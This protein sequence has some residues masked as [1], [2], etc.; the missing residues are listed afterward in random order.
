[1]NEGRHFGVKRGHDLVGG[2]D[3]ADGQAAVPQILGHLDADETAADDNRGTRGPGRRDEG[4]GVFDI[5]Q[6]QRTLDPGNRRSHGASTRGQD[7]RAIRQLRLD[8]GGQLTNPHDLARAVDSD[9]LVSDPHIEVEPRPE[10]LRGL[11]Q[12]RRAAFDHPTHVIGQPTVR[13]RHI[14]AAFQHDDLGPLVQ[15]T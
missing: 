4:V 15:T 1:M 7:E 8:L 12:Q 9:D 10:R 6:G 13:E 11:Q 5:A 14:A 3:K 2:F